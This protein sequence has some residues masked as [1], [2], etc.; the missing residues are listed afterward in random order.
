M[1]NTLKH[2]FINTAQFI[3]HF[4]KRQN[5]IS[6]VRRTLKLTLLRPRQIYNLRL[7]DEFSSKVFYLQNLFLDLEQVAFSVGQM[8]K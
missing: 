7:S 4:Y 8:H 5:M 2:R 6:M 1:T 3:F